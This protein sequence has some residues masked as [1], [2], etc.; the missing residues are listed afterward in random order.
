MIAIVQYGDGLN[1]MGDIVFV[2]GIGNYSI[3]FGQL[4]Q[5][6]LFWELH[7]E[8]QAKLVLKGLIK[9]DNIRVIF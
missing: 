8:V 4:P 6:T 1:N 5:L 7:L 3:Y 9:P 2:Q